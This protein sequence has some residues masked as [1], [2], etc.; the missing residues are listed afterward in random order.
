MT[1]KA[2]KID[3]LKLDLSN[4]RISTASSQHDAMQK[5]IE[6]QD[7]KLAYLAENIVDEAS[8]NPMDRLLG[9]VVN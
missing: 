9:P 3:Q 2:L 5:I 1:A 7:I 6:D 4:P 8:M